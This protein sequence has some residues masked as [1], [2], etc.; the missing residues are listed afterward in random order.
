MKFKRAMFLLLVSPITVLAADKA[1]QYREWDAEDYSRNNWV[2]QLIAEKAIAKAQLSFEGY[3]VLDAGCG[4][5]NISQQISEKAESVYACDASK[6][7][8]A[9]AQALYPDAPGLTIQYCPIEDLDTH[10]E[11]HNKFDVITAFSVLHFIKDKAKA[12]NNF[13]Y[14]LKSGGEVLIA[15]TSESKQ[16]LLSRQAA[17]ETLPFLET[18]ASIATTIKSRFGSNLD[19]MAGA[20]YTTSEQLKEIVTQAGFEILLFDDTEMRPEFE[21]REKL[22][23]FMWSLVSTIPLAKALPELLTKLFFARFMDKLVPKLEFNSENG[24][25]IYPHP[26]TI[27]HLKKK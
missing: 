18:F 10:P 19:A 22:D 12:L 20:Q 21:S 1:P 9:K 11:L 14:C 7:M 4:T 8:I 26:L 25:Y 15:L 6:N 16:E 23:A 13:N 24:H 5:C 27:I 3:S 17:R 2:Q